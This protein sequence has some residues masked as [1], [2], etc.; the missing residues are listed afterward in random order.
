[1][2]TLTGDTL[3]DFSAL[4]GVTINEVRQAAGLPLI[5]GPEGGIALNLTYEN[6][7]KKKPSADS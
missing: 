5:P 6:V 3:N 1:M 2:S 4:P 7:R